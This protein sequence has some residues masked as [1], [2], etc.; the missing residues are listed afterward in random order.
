MSK[1]L[2]KP[3]RFGYSAK[4]DKIK[5]KEWYESME[6]FVDANIFQTWAFDEIRLKDH[7]RSHLILK[8]KNEINIGFEN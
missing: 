4:F 7:K 3:L 5:K 6:K 1:I 2:V 8:Y